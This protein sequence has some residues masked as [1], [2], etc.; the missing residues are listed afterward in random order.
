MSELR[1]ARLQAEEE[2]R[3]KSQSHNVDGRSVKKEHNTQTFKC[4]ETNILSH[5][6]FATQL[7]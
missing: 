1:D 5:C 3:T 2:V 7:S 6:K 4:I